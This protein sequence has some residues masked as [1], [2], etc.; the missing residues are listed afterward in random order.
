MPRRRFSRKMSHAGVVKRRTPKRRSSKRNNKSRLGV[1][2][3]KNLDNNK[4]YCLK[5]QG[6]V[7]C[8]GVK[9]DSKVMRNG[10]KRLVAQCAKCNT[11]VYRILPKN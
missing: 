9:M 3:M 10:C 6:V 1:P 4:F 2:D 7:N 5:C 8:K 11:K